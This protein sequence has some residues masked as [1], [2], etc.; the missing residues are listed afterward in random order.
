MLWLIISIIPMMLSVIL[1]KG[2][3]KTH[4]NSQQTKHDQA[5]NLIKL[6]C[7]NNGKINEKCCQSFGKKQGNRA[8]ENSKKESPHILPVKAGISEDNAYVTLNAL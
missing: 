5:M 8:K 3:S 6:M 1:G 4:I 7:I 2:G